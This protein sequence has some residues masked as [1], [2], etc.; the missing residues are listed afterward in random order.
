MN[1]FDPLRRRVGHRPALANTSFVV[2]TL[3]LW[4]IEDDTARVRVSAM[5]PVVNEAFSAREVS[6][7]IAVDDLPELLSL[8]RSDP[9]ATLHKFF[10]VDLTRMRTRTR[11]EAQ[12]RVEAQASSSDE[13]P[14]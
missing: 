3:T 8:Y 7:I 6:D 5:V 11:T 10:D 2:P 14:L 9:E 4:F 13:I 12:A 1:L